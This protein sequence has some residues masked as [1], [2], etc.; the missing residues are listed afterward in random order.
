MVSCQGRPQDSSWRG[1]PANT[2]QGGPGKPSRDKGWEEEWKGRLPGAQRARTGVCVCRVLPRPRRVGRRFPRGPSQATS[3][4]SYCSHARL[5]AQSCRWPGP[6]SRWASA[7]LGRSGGPRH[8][9]RAVC[10]CTV[11][12]APR[13]LAPHLHRRHVVWPQQCPTENRGCQLGPLKPETVGRHVPHEW[14]RCVQSE[15]ALGT[16]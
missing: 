11:S 16:D 1:Q 15:L 8:P 2:H 13:M 7:L 5:P 9:R 6:R 14:T 12:G 10:L 4:L 3:G